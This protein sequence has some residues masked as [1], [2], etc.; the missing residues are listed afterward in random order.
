MAAT[1]ICQTCGLPKD[2]C[3]CQ[4]LAKEKQKIRVY[5]ERRRYNKYY[6]IVDGF[7]STVDVHSLT[8]DLK[9]KLACGGTFKNN[10]I[11]LQGN[12]TGK[13]KDILVKMNFPSDQ[14]DVS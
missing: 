3:V 4:E 11:E 12:H 8:K 2:I 5:R 10:R 9:R 1:L 7:D 13:I 14:I 6:T